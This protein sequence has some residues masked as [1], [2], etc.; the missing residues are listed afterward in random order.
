MTRD[1]SELAELRRE[2]RMTRMYVDDDD[3]RAEI[4]SW[5]AES[6]QE[7]DAGTAR[8]YVEERLNEMLEDHKMYHAAETKRGEDEFP[9][10]CEG[11]RHYG[12]A[13][14]VLRDRTETQWR[15]RRLEDA[16][17]ERDARRVYQE[18]A[19]DVGCHRIPEFLSA[20]D[21]SFAELLEHGQDLLSRVEDHVHETDT[22]Q[23]EPTVDTG[24]ET[25]LSDGGDEP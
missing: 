14:P 16:D 24:G 5:I 2:L 23:D 21:S 22:E 20:W 11:C 10:E 4:K 17:T 18:Q 9:D 12:A 3:L 15:S 19:R 6:H 8:E 13:C 1:T 7:S 25:V